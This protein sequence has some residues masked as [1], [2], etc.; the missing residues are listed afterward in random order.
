MERLLVVL[1]PELLEEQEDGRAARTFA[2]VV[3]VVE[4][5]SP[6]AGAV[7]PGVCAVPT[8]G[9]SRYFGGDVRLAGLVRT[10]L[11]RT[12]TALGRVEGHIGVADGLFVAVLAAR[13]AGDEPVVVPAGA[14][15]RFLAPWPVEALERP[16]LAD[17]LRRLGI[18]T[19]GAFA[20][21]PTRHVLGR[22]GTQGSVCHELARGMR[23]ELP[24]YRLVPR[25]HPATAATGDGSA[26]AQV[27]Q[28][29]FWGE[30]A[31]AEARAE[32]ALGH[33]EQLLPPDGVAVGRLQGGRGPAERAR[34]VPWGG[35]RLDPAGPGPEPWPGQLPAPAPA[36]VLA[37]VPASVVDGRGAELE[38]GPSGLPS[39]PPE[40]L[41]VRGGP[42]QPVTAWAGPWPVDE[43]WWSRRKR[44]RRARMQ[45]V[46]SCGMAYL[47][48]REDAGWWVE[49]AYD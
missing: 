19:L 31:E 9:P 33:L 12:D 21:L 46:T 8:R 2:G 16:E 18:R 41:S 36:S 11:S 45:L 35:R 5:F 29:G 7:R 43:R 47:V 10:A 4:S 25:P 26:G 37:R 14:S 30:A 48:V 40:Q 39:A 22:L 23:S 20:A 6:A 28:A 1:C 27:R 38:V 15:A 42:W 13:A 49:G 32:R 44:R 3:E 17:L 24:G 34:L